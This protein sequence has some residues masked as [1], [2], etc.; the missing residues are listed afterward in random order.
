MRGKPPGKSI[1]A[2]TKKGQKVHMGAMN[3]RT[4]FADCLF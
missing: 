2:W 3:N 1:C 4:K